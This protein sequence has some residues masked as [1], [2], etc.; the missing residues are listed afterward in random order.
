MTAQLVFMLDAPIASWTDHPGG[1]S[2]DAV[3]SSARDPGKSHLAGLVGAAL[4][5]GRAGLGDLAAS[6]RVAALC[7]REPV[8][9]LK[10]DYHTMARGHPLGGREPHSRFDQI[11]W[12]LA[13]QGSC[14][15]DKVDATT[16]SSR[17]HVTGGLWLV[18]LTPVPGEAP[19]DLATMAAALARP[20]YVPFAGRKALTL[21]APPDPEVI[22]ADGPL[23]A[24]RR[25]A[26]SR[27][28]LAPRHPRREGGG[29]PRV[30]LACE[31]GYPGAPEGNI[32]RVR[33]SDV[34]R[35][36]LSEGGLMRL[37]A[38]REEAQ[39]WHAWPIQGNDA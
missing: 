1:S 9:D 13:N 23:D 25:Y 26:G 39:T 30:R 32:R 2:T 5:T 35:P 27:P 19:M 4:G 33:R 7:L 15:G 28:K 29:L 37:Y 36:R 6:L 11:R 34:P 10:P 12:Q 31:A 38:A 22:D 17:E 16:L 8:P 3:R 14:A 21:G 24:V 18:S 20:R